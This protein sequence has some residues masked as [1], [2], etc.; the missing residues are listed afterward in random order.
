[1]S[2]H[3]SFL[4]PPLLFLL[5]LTYLLTSLS[6]PL[7]TSLFV[8]NYWRV[9]DEREKEEVDVSIGMDRENQ[10]EEKGLEREKI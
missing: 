8:L 5:F 4:S 2:Y 10:K 1:L 9:E 3:T 6:F 7:K